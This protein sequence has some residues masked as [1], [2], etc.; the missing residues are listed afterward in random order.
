MNFLDSF[1]K[2]LDSVLTPICTKIMQ[3]K[4]ISA[5]SNSMMK[6]MPIFI[7][8]AIFS[9]IANFPI[10]AV[11]TFLTDI[12]IK[13]I[14]DT[15]VTTQTNLQP[16][17]LAF[18]ISHTYAKNQ[19]ADGVIAGI[20]SLLTY[21]MLMPATFNVGEQVFTAYSADY[22]GGQGIFAAIIISIVISKIY[23]FTVQKHLVFKLP[24]S[25]PP[26]VSKSFEPI[27]SGILIIGL[28]LLIS[29]IFQQTSYGNFF[30]AI[31]TLVQTPI[32]SVGASVPAMM[33]FYTVVNL[34]WFFGIHPSAL[35]AI[36]TPVLTTIMASN[37]GAMM[38]GVEMPYVGEQV[39]Y[40]VS[41]MGGTGCT[42]GLVFV[43]LIFAKSQRFKAMNKLC[44]VPGICNINEPLIF[45]MPLMMNPLFFFP[46]ILSAP[47]NIALITVFSKFVPFSFNAVAAMSAP[48]TMPWPI[49]GFLAGGL[50]L[51]LII[52]LIVLVDA[53]LF[54]PF[55]IVADR[56]ELAEEK[57]LSAQQQEV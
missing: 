34:F 18:I 5:I 57:A 30:T 55:F 17:F 16:I 29:F 49:T 54:L 35:M 44:A 21:F 10:T 50:P 43:M 4:T 27:Y 25:V 48:W 9:L 33:L 46:M 2:K 28:G 11:T 32:M 31:V 20:F 15:F 37:A 47:L 22:M 51:C 13:P 6:L 19:N 52:L 56:K 39:A 24:D 7:G 1:Q 42:L 45:G 23:V 53:F 14:L 3:N 26:M 41:A 36:F 38:Q 12:G 40:M 8:G